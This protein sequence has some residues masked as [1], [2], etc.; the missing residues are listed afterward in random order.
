MSL[1]SEIS[2]KELAAKNGRDRYTPGPWRI[3]KARTCVHILAP[4]NGST[5]C[6]ATMAN[7][8]TKNPNAVLISVAPELLE[9]LKQYVARSDASTAALN[10]N[11]RA[12]IEKVN[13]S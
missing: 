12:V 11:A 7:K 5:T 3:S 6:I 10:N 8:D 13:D 1:K 4:W 2:A 9:L